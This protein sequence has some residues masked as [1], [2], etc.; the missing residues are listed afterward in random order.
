MDP[1][2]E[3]PRVVAGTQQ[4][5]ARRRERLAAGERHLGWK[6]AFGAPAALEQ[7]GLAAPVLGFLTDRSVVEPG[8]RVRVADW[9][10][11]GLEPEIAVY[12]AR[13]LPADASPADAVAAIGEIGAA[14][15]LIDTERPLSELEE[16]LPA[17]V[18]HRHV[19]LGRGRAAW[20]ERDAATLPVRVL[21]D[22]EE[23]AATRRPAQA[24]GEVSVLV[25]H[26]ARYLAAFGERLGAGDLVMTGS[27]TPLVAA[28]PGH[29]YR[30][31]IAG[32]GD[33]EVQ[34][35]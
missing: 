27:A 15:E 28:E 19:V 26:V 13:E 10:K 11:P 4:Q 30:V 32:L 14:I 22:G 21:R 2:W 31:E 23:V 33:V 29:L 17:N 25:A 9:T 12:L 20:G 7:T 5:L 34:L 3:D 8:A 35:D 16:N 1:S 18:F 24:T 6:L